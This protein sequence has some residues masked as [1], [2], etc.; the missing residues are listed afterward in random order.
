MVPKTVL[1]ACLLSLVGLGLGAPVAADH[2]DT[3][4]P[5]LPSATF[6]FPDGEPEATDC[7]TLPNG[8]QVTWINLDIGPHDPGDGRQGEDVSAC[9]QASRDGGLLHPGD[10]Y[11]LEVHVEDGELLVR[12]VTSR[13]GEVVV[14]ERLC[15][16]QDVWRSG[17]Y[18]DDDG[19]AV[20]PW[21]C[22][23]HEPPG[24]HGFIVVD[25]P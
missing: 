12:N 21:R 4:C 14:E 20:L 16:S 25:L 2:A 3:T 8:G 9:F 19:D 18:L 11:S 6:L 17:W 10:T 24:R 15:P 1:L 7:V 5:A 13:T 22:H 23:I